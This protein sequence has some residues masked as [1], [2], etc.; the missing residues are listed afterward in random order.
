MLYRHTADG[1][2]CHLIECVTYAFAGNLTTC[3]WAITNNRSVLPFNECRLS[4]VGVISHDS[5]LK[6]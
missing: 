6:Y 1:T 4:W 2:Q 3:T 5:I